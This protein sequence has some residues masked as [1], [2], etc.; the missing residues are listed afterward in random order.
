[1]K[2][3]V[4][5]VA[6]STQLDLTVYTKRAIQSL[7]RCENDKFQF[8]ITIVETGKIYPFFHGSKTIIYYPYA[9]FNY[10]RA[11]NLGIRNTQNRYIIL[12]NNDVEFYPGFMDA[13][14]NAFD[15]GYLSLNPFDQKRY[16][17]KKVKLNPIYEGYKVGQILFGYCIAVDRKIF[18]IIGQ[19]D[20]T[21]N[22]W[23][24]DHVY[25]RQL[26][27]HEIKH[28]LVTDANVQHLESK[29]LDTLDLNKKLEYT[30]GQ[31]FIYKGMI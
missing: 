4:I 16:N 31:K 27:S 20:E 7:K 1:M 13:L 10:N 6:D 12:T 18:D 29:T 30:E 28:A 26:K 24:S 19:I 2:I 8:D 25:A 11:L 22:F 23:Y 21:V 14:M 5:I 9:N 15:K 17:P 3:D